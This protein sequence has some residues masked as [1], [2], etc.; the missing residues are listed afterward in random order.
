[1]SSPGSPGT[2]IKSLKTVVAS[3]KET[4]ADILQS[5][6]PEGDV[7]E[8]IARAIGTEVNHSYLQHHF[9]ELSKKFEVH[10]V[11]MRSALRDTDLSVESLKEQVKQLYDLH[12][13]SQEKLPTY[14]QV[15]TLHGRLK[16]MEAAMAEMK[17]GSGD[18]EAS[19]KLRIMTREKDSLS[20]EKE[21]LT[22]K[23]RKSEKSM[24]KLLADLA[25]KEEQLTQV[26]TAYQRDKEKQEQQHKRRSEAAEKAW[27]QRKTGYGKN[28]SG[29]GEP[30]EE[31]PPASSSS[32][33]SSSSSLLQPV[34]QMR[35]ADP[36]APGGEFNKLGLGSGKPPPKQLIKKS[37]VESE[38]E[39]SEEYSE[40]DEER[41]QV[42]EAWRKKS[43]GKK[44]SK[45]ESKQ[46]S[47]S[48]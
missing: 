32:S 12:S 28:K 24:N 31:K 14:Y 44:D 29:A 16:K 27:Q 42:R 22:E 34:P 37:R 35:V 6:G 33:S 17:E 36:Y 21:E 48:E 47:D 25:R 45:G 2:K 38:S 8:T 11:A 23:L 7:A 19:K 41:D 18:P 40:S 46:E 4:V 3:I 30:S 43:K 9:D 13:E 15:E 20:E 26:T 1:M 5:F 10:S 39:S